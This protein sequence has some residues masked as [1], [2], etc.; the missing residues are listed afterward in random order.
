MTD[1]EVGRA[2]D[3]FFRAERSI[4]LASLVQ[5]YR[6]L[7]LAE[8][9]T[10]DAIESALKHWPVD[11]VPAKPGAWLLTT[12]RRKAVDR[13][14]R[15]QTLAA[16]VGVL[17]ANTDRREPSHLNSL[18]ETLPDDRLQLFFTCAHPALA[19]GDRLALTLR[20]LAGLTTGEVARAL[21]IP[22]AT[23]A[24]RIVRAKNKI[25]AARIPFRLPGPDELA[26]RV[27]MVLE[28][29]YSIFTEGYSATSGDHVGRI[30]LTDEALG[31][32]RL[33]YAA[34]PTES[35]VI[36]LLALMLLVDARRDARTGPDGEI[37]LLADQD[38]RLWNAEFIAEG[39]ELV[40]EALGGGRSGPYALQAAIAALHDE[41][42]DADSTDW[43]QIVALY[44]VLMT[45]APSPIVALNRA[46]ALAMR[47]GP[48]AGLHEL[49]LLAD[50][51]S[52][53][54]YHPYPMARADL[55]Q[56]LGR[57]EE[58]AI[59]YRRA[60]DFART[61]PEKRL[62]RGRLAEVRAYPGQADSTT[63]T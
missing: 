17:Q 8:E 19:A 10:S 29:I 43:P 23:A 50:E 21:L 55:L 34:L 38:R 14:R 6:D 5:R 26:G 60:L 36:G 1:V 42:L 48:A 57:F 35:E 46:V 54:R 51:P 28:V 41:S 16:R 59:D 39:R 11:G 3:S 25:R 7:D 4:L 18:D 63:S 32:G 27:P 12:A 56:R 62:L 24:Q 58:A 30:D 37:V 40:V 52:L 2:L 9:V 33:L 22:P 13:L 15:G 20:C 47:D 53:R 49:N 44:D 61:A 45:R 31:M